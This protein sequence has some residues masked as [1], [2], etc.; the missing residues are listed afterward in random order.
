[1]TQYHYKFLLKG[2]GNIYVSC[3]T[4]YASLERAMRSLEQYIARGQRGELLTRDENN[5]IIEKLEF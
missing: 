1:M 4:R 2:E 5:N 3:L